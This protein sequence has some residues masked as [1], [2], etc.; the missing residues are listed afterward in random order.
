MKYC[1]VQQEGYEENTWLN[2][3]A[4]KYLYCFHNFKEKLLVNQHQK[5]STITNHKI[6]EELHSVT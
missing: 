6:K 1:V 3:L 2:R 4:D 5:L